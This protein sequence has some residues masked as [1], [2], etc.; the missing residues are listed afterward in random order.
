MTNKEAIQELNKWRR[1]LENQRDGVD[2][3]PWDMAVKALSEREEKSNDNN[4]I[5]SN[6]VDDFT[7]SDN[8]RISGS[9]RS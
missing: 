4:D 1:F 8:S 2:P 6:S 7:L 9:E 3:E 5:N